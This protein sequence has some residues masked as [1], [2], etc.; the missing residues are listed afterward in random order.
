VSRCKYQIKD[1]S[2]VYSVAVRYFR[3]AAHRMYQY[4]LPMAPWGLKYVGVYSVNKFVLT[5]I[6]ALVGFWRKIEPS[7]W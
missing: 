3:D 2:V 1:Q 4:S 7:S 6:S 5:C